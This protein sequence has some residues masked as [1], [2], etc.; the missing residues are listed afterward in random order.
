MRSTEA[1]SGGARGRSLLCG[2]AGPV[3]M[4]D[5]ASDGVGLRFTTLRCAS[6][7]AIGLRRVRTGEG[8]DGGGD[9]GRWYMVSGVRADV[10]VP[11]VMGG[12]RA[13][14]YVV[15]ENRLG[16]M[17]RS[18]RPGKFARSGDCSG[19]MGNCVASV[20]HVVQLKRLPGM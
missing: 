14:L 16:G 7:R 9:I 13:V 18:C 20:L 19:V 17:S 3:P 2:V 1:S 6:G 5:A 12:E 4:V 10:S 8:G 15:H 11:L